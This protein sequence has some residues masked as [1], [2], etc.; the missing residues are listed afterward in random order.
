[1]NEEQFDKGVAA[2]QAIYGD[3]RLLPAQGSMRPLRVAPRPHSHLLLGRG[4]HEVAR[5]LRPGEPR[6]DEAT[7]THG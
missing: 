6:R 5:G 2:V 3:T 1:M 7:G 4:E